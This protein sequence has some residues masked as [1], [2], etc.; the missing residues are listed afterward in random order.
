M[1]PQ[2]SVCGAII[3][4]QETAIKLPHPDITTDFTGREERCMDVCIE[5]SGNHTIYLRLTECAGRTN[6][7]RGQLS[8]WNSDGAGTIRVCDAV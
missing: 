7:R 2:D 5:L 6:D 8:K 1:A 3:H 4:L